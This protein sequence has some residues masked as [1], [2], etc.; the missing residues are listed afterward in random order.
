MECECNFTALVS[1]ATAEAVNI[2]V[3]VTTISMTRASI[4]VPVGDVVPSSFI[5]FNITRS[6]NAAEIAPAS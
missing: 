6:V 5:G 3:N 1:V 4:S 2:I